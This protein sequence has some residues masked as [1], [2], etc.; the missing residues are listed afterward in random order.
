MAALGAV[1]MAG[2]PQEQGTR[3][4]GWGSGAERRCGGVQGVMS[5]D[6][7]D[8]C[9]TKQTRDQGDTSLF[10]FRAARSSFLCSASVRSTER[11]RSFASGT[12]LRTKPSRVACQT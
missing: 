11:M 6:F 12:R 3:D 5:E 2:G 10:S 8:K 4:P 7:T 1:R 9:G